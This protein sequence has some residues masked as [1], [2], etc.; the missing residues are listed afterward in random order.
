MKVGKGGRGGGGG[1]KRERERG[2][3]RER[4]LVF[5]NDV[6]PGRLTMFQWKTTHTRLINNT[7]WTYWLKQNKTIQYKTKQSKT[8]TKTKK[9]LICRMGREI[10]AGRRYRV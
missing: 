10:G 6:I 4:E 7:N 8:K 9:T 5:F 2:R 1:G 3:E